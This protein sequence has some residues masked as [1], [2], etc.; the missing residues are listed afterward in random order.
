M[1]EAAILQH[2]EEK[3][4]DRIG[5]MDIDANCFECRHLHEDQQTCDAFPD[6]IPT[7]LLF[8]DE[9]H[10][11]PYPGDHG[12]QFEPILHPFARGGPRS[13]P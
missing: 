1:T 4:L 6:G 2:G 8:L 10:D 7:A 9:T 3:R 11:R 12:I 5:W 13:K